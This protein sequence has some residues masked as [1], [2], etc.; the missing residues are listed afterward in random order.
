MS[1][2]RLSL[3]KSLRRATLNSR[4]HINNADRNRK[5][6]LARAEN[7]RINRTQIATIREVGQ[8]VE[9]T[10]TETTTTATIADA[11][12]GVSNAMHNAAPTL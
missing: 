4:R 12:L 9:T 7:R 1:R 10:T 5:A 8:I 2:H 6:D 11:N 3:E